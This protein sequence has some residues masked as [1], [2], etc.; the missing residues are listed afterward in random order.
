M[1]A[2]FE[3][4]PENS[5]LVGLLSTLLAKSRYFTS[6]RQGKA[7]KLSRYAKEEALGEQNGPQ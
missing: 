2:R 3:G 5:S 7:P 1:Q 6:L 4:G